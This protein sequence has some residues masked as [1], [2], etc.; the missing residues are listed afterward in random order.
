MLIIVNSN[1]IQD[2][3][4][5]SINNTQLGIIT[6]LTHDI[7]N[8]NEDVLLIESSRGIEGNDKSVNFWRFLTRYLW[9][10]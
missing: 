10:K 4:A 1:Q 9:N 7:Q 6:L 3:L 5:A 2:N 8:K